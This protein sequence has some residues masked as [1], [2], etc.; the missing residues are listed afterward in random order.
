MLMAAE[1]PASRFAGYEISESGLEVARALTAEKGLSNLSFELIDVTQ[2][3]VA[4]E[5]R[6]FDLITTF[7]AVHDQVAPDALLAWIC[8]ALQLGGTYLMQDIAG[9][10]DVSKNV[11]HPI[12]PF[13]YTISTMHC[14]TVSLAGD[15]AGLGTMWGED[16][17]LSMLRDAGFT[18]VEIKRLDHDIQNAYYVSRKD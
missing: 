13:L 15:G 14:M 8:G 16:L 9:S 12:G 1:F 11:D 7:D 6:E 3:P 2:E 4:D 17:A 18:S 10:S 5:S